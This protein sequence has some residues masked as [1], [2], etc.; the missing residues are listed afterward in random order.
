MSTEHPIRVLLV[1]DHP[2]ILEGLCALLSRA[3]QIRVVAQTESGIA[4]VQAYAEYRPDVVLLDLGLPDINGIEVIGRI[5]K[6][7]PRAR[8]LVLTLRTGSIDVHRSVQAGC[9][10]YLLKNSRREELLDAIEMVHRGELY[11]PAAIARRMAERCSAEMLSPREV[12]VLN[13]V[14]E[15]RR[16][17]EIAT[18]LALSMPTVKTHLRNILA[19]LGV[20]SRSQAII[21]G[22]ESGV[23]APPE[24]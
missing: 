3:S 8:I 18:T 19:K 23:I 22:F 24:S 2:V 5:R 20:S 16:D 9:R 10:G 15:G 13:L 21:A 4:A 6:H 14:A 1:D 17:K 11:F 12:E 7:D